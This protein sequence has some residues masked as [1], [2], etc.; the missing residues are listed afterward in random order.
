V[1][2]RS[3]I[4]GGAKQRPERRQINS[5]DHDNDDHSVAKYVTPGADLVTCISCLVVSLVGIPCARDGVGQSRLM[6][7]QRSLDRCRFVLSSQVGVIRAGPRWSRHRHPARGDN[8]CMSAMQTTV[9]CQSIA[10]TSHDRVAVYRAV[11]S[12][13]R[14]GHPFHSARPRGVPLR[15]RRR[16]T[17]ARTT[18]TRSAQVQQFR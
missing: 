2:S 3:A 18:A 12:P 14:H 16:S 11:R 7:R 9:H 10:H 4:T 8:R 6:H 15:R 1:L 17:A 13:H 5:F